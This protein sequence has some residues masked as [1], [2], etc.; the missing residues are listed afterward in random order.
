MSPQPNQ[1]FTQP[2][3]SLAPPSSA[4]RP[5]SPRPNSTITRPSLPPSSNASTYAGPAFVARTNVPAAQ[6]NAPQYNTHVDARNATTLNIYNYPNPAP[7]AEPPP[8]NQTYTFHQYRPGTLSGRPGAA[9]I[10]PMP[11]A[12]TLP[13]KKRRGKWNNDDYT[14]EDDARILWLYERID[15]S[16]KTSVRPPLWRTI[17][18]TLGYDN[19]A[20]VSGRFGRE[21]KKKMPQLRENSAYLPP[22][23]CD[24]R[25]LEPKFRKDLGGGGGGGS[26]GASTGMNT[27]QAG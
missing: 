5:T 20:S 16:S 10:A 4:T 13:D 11:Q 6:P 14:E 15:K 21:I 19:E 12:S 22:P 8:T 1:A 7:Q 2:S 9:S 18:E 24:P 23:N 17:T 3:A 26:G 25:I 27:I